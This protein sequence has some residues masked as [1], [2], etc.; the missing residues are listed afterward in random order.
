[1]THGLGRI[2]HD[3]PRD[4]AYPMQAVLA[5]PTEDTK[6]HWANGLWADQGATGTCVGHAWAH[7]IEDGP[8][9]W[10]GDIDPFHVYREACQRDPWPENDDGDLQFGT[11]VRAGAKY[12]KESGRIL[13]YRWAWTLEPIVTALLTRGPVVVGSS[14]YAGMFEP[15]SKGVITWQGGSS[16]YVG[17]HAYLLNG[18]NTNTEMLRLKNSWSRD[19]ANKGHA[20]ISFSDFQRLLDDGAEAC[21]AVE[22]D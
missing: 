20:W 15:D 16:N 5:V 19:W 8:A 4:A 11:S 9:T 17:G 12:L 6:Y 22:A 10:P 21:L 7:W 1:M 2:Q 13:E 3:D 18:V 14:W